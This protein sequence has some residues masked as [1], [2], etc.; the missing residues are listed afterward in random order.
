[1]YLK[2][3]VIVRPQPR[4]NQLLFCLAWNFHLQV[5]LKGTQ[6]SLDFYV[7]LFPKRCKQCC[8]FSP[9]SSIFLLC[10]LLITNTM[11][12]IKLCGV[13]APLA[14]FWR[15]IPK[16][17]QTQA[18]NKHLTWLHGQGFPYVAVSANLLLSIMIKNRSC[19][20]IVDSKAII[21]IV[22]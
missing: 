19:F 1:M 12:T 10:C 16:S 18:P 3:H 22:N 9:Q 21:G 13:T 5:M 14:S 4:D 8:E 15:Q 20:D 7:G 2:L 17:H 6:V 11:S